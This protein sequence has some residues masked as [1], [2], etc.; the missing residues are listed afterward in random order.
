MTSIRYRLVRRASAQARR[1]RSR[2]VLPNDPASNRGSRLKKFGI[3]AEQCA[4][5]A[6]FPLFAAI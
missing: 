6:L 1:V 5:V 3:H 2:E 4:W